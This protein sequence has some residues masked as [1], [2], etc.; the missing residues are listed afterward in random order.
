MIGGLS[1]FLKSEFIELT[2]VERPVIFTANIPDPNWIAGFVTVEFCLKLP[3]KG[4]C[5]DVR[6]TQST[7]KIG[8]RVQLRFRITQHDRDIKLMEYII[9]YLGAGQIYKYPKIS[10]V[11]L[12]IVKYSDIY[13]KIIP[14]LFFV[15]LFFFTKILF[16]LCFCLCFCSYDKTHNYYEKTQNSYDKIKNYYLY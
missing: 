15:C 7:T 11:N 13:N 4:G 9:K 10:A 5:F 3:S 16:F 12:T 1:Y 14:F 8:Q 6:I 2:P